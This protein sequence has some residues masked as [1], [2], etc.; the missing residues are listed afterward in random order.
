VVTANALPKSLKNGT[1]KRDA[2]QPS[3][4]ALMFSPASSWLRW[5]YE[6]CSSVE[7]GNRVSECGDLG[8][9]LAVLDCGMVSMTTTWQLRSKT[10][11]A[12]GGLASTFKLFSSVF[13]L[14]V[15]VS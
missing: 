3:R 8:D 15:Q 13:H 4:P 12:F 10:G 7:S 1:K 2:R 9:G 14:P 11:E 5:G 6:S